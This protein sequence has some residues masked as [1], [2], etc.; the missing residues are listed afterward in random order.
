[1]HFQLAQGHSNLERYKNGF[2]NLALPFFAFSEPI[3]A[4]KSK[5]RR[6]PGTPPPTPPGP[7]LAVCV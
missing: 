3:Q 5:V 6:G 4:P 1:M 7:A 2:A